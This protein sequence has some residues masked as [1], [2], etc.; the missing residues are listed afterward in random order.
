MTFNELTKDQSPKTAIEK[1]TLRI[2]TWADRP[3]MDNG[4]QGRYLADFLAEY[5]EM[6]VCPIDAV[7]GC[8]AARGRGIWIKP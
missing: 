2:L 6:Q 3:Y 7:M 5:G 1:D 8:P 4:R